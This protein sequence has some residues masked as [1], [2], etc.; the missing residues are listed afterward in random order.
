MGTGANSAMKYIL[1]A[2]K[3]SSEDHCRGCVMDTYDSDYKVFELTS[4]KEVDSKIAELEYTELKPSE[5]GYYFTV[6]R[7][8]TIIQ[9]D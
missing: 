7:G 5:Y 9:N 6:I 3:P 8:G 1:I 2:Y 4:K